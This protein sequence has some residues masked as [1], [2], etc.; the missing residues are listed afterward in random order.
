MKKVYFIQNPEGRIF[1][2]S[3]SYDKQICIRQFV[4]SWWD[5]WKV[6]ASDYACDI[7]WKQFEASGFRLYEVELPEKLA[8]V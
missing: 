6:K 2:D 4:N 8:V 3:V 7:I 1:Q 5:M